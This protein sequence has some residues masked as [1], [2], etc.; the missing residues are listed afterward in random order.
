MSLC[1][2][3]HSLTCKSEVSPNMREQFSAKAKEMN[4]C[5]RLESKE[6]LPTDNG[7]LQKYTGLQGLGDCK[8]PISTTLMRE[9][10]KEGRFIKSCSDA[11]KELNSCQSNALPAKLPVVNQARLRCTEGFCLSRRSQGIDT[12]TCNLATGLL[13]NVLRNL[14]SERRV[15]GSQRITGEK[16]HPLLLVKKTNQVYAWLL[17][18]ATFKPLNLHGWVMS[19]SRRVRPGVCNTFKLC[20]EVDDN[21]FQTPQLESY[22]STVCFLQQL[23]LFSCVKTGQFSYI[24]YKYSFWFVTCCFTAFQIRYGRNCYQTVQWQ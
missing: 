5:Q 10:S 8:Y 12:A 19:I 22:W 13:K 1:E 17:A 11:W 3:Q 24:L 2:N 20:F 21:G 6:S 14:R 16:R 9:L 7:Q 18:R 15:K 4:R 23:F